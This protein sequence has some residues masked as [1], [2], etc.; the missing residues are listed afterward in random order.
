MGR[1]LLSIDSLRRLLATWEQERALAPT[2]PKLERVCVAL[3]AFV[4]EECLGKV[5]FRWA[6]TICADLLRE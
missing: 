1:D 6:S 3:R 2:Q 4:S 5:S